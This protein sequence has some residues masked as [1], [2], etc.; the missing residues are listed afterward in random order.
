MGKTLYDNSEAARAVFDAAGDELKE[1]IFNGSAEELNRTDIT[2]PAVFTVGFAAWEA[3]RNKLCGV[4]YGVAGFS[5]GEYGALTAAGVISDFRTG[6][7]IVKHRGIFMAEAGRYADGTSRGAMAAVIG[8]RGNVV[9]AVDAARKGDVLEAVNFN[10]PQQT[11]VAGDADAIARLKSMGKERGLRVIPLKVSTAFHSPIME[12]ASD[13]LRE[14][15]SSFEFDKPRV[16][17]YANTTAR[18]ITVHDITVDDITA[19]DIDAE[20][21]AGGFSDYIRGHMAAQL[22]SPVYWQETIE[23]MAADGIDVFIETGP[24]KTLSGLASK[25]L[26]DARVV[27][28]DA[29]G[30]EVAL[31]LIG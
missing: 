8:A 17:L 22:K 9:E 3:L 19:H 13:R 14:Y 10:S 23:N 4:P 27:S 11:A 31:E 30:L 5:L 29:D 25:I 20:F 21:G 26:P 7:E 1:L 24:G 16:K 28:I 15:V 18:D 2:Q 12:P 6:L